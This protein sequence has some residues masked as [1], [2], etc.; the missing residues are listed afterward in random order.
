M[1]VSRNEDPK[2]DYLQKVRELAT[3]N[4][5]VLVF[6]ECTSGFRETFGGL[7][8]KYKVEPDLAIFAKSLG[9]GYAI[10]ACIGRQEFMFDKAEI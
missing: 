5:I 9:N 6:D 1:E 2:D 3:E 4:H 8:K 10:S 7:H